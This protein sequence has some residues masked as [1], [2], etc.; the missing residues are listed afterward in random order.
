MEGPEEDATGEHHFGAFE[1]PMFSDETLPQAPRVMDAP[2][3]FRPA[4]T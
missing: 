2:S 1:N 4:G 3:Q